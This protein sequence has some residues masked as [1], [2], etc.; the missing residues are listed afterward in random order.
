MKLLKSEQIALAKIKE[1]TKNCKNTIITNA[2]FN[3]KGLK[4]RHIIIKATNSLV[5]KGLIIKRRCN[6]EIFRTGENWIGND[7]YYRYQIKQSAL[8]C[9]F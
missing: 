3:Q 5:E 4:G 2:Q 9:I 1:L 6:D 8:L 7:K